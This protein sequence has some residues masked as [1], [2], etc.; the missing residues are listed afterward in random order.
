MYF[1]GIK[2]HWMSFGKEKKMIQV[3]DVI[4]EK[5]QSTKSMANENEKLTYNKLKREINDAQNEI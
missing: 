4:N 3:A 1:F 5:Q 2:T